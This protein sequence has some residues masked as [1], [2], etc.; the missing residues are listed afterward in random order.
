MRSSLKNIRQLITV[1]RI[2]ARHDAL[3][4]FEAI[5]FY[6]IIIKFVKLFH[7][8]NPTKR[9]GERLVSALSEAGPSFIKLG[10]TISTRSDIFGE[11]LTHDLSSLQDQLPPFSFKK[12][13]ETIASELEGEISNLFKSFSN[14]PVAAASIAQVHFATTNEGKEVAVKVLR[15]NIEESFYKDLDLF[16]WLAQIIEKSRPEYKR[17]KLSEV[18]KTIENSMKIEMDLRL[19][20]AAASELYD[21]FKN[22]LDFIIP[23]IDWTLTSRRVMT[24]ER[25]KGIPIDDYSAII[26]AGLNPNTVFKKLSKISFNQ[27][28]R[29]G[30]FHADIH[31]GNIFVTRSGAISAV[32]FGIMGRLDFATRKYLGQI[33]LAFLNRD[34]KLAGKLHFKA[35]WIPSNQ[36][37]DLFSQACRAIGEPIL[38]KPQDEISIAQLLGLLFQISETFKMEVQPQ[39]LLLQKT[40]LVAEGTSRKLAPKANM[41]LTARPLMENWM[42]S[43]L[44]PE[45]KVRMTVDTLSN[46]VEKLPRLIDNIEKS[47]TIM[48][49]GL[50]KVDPEILKL[51][52]NDYKKSTFVYRTL[53]LLLLIIGGY[54]G[55]S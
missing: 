3:F 7:R 5:D 9:P 25:I 29:D 48:A 13:Q 6:P 31:P 54:L 37:E 46:I 50:I 22:D 53:I 33:L 26:E 8:K 36:S 35:G 32:D 40:M 38:D 24:A 34:Y 28:F 27:V 15:P 21:N 12:V 10:Q 43:N 16:T 30:F 49:N 19:E 47:T 4:P 44:G 52:Q 17:L 39:L 1:L 11:Q 51:S 20:A 14:K 41:W 18:I 23:K 45:A 55:F 2:F 42:R